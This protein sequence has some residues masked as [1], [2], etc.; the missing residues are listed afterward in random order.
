MFFDTM[1]E[2]NE[3]NAKTWPELS[4]HLITIGKCRIASMTLTV[5]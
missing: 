1:E 5:A 4:D 2:K 3:T